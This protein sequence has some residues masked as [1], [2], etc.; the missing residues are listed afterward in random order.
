MQQ[1][2]EC[3]IISTVAYVTRYRM[4]SFVLTTFFFH[5]LVNPCLQAVTEAVYLK[6]AVGQKYRVNFSSKN[7][8]GEDSE[9]IEDLVCHLQH[10][11]D[12]ERTFICND[13]WDSATFTVRYLLS[14]TH[15]VLT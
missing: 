9:D 3:Q 12:K 11:G 1:S 8:F 10:G 2:G 5:Y 15:L 14:Q 6:W 7:Y 13:E 4:S